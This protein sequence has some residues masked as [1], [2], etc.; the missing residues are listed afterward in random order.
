VAWDER[1]IVRPKKIISAV[2]DAV[3]ARAKEFGV[4]V[5]HAACWPPIM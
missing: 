2:K 3:E 5:R 4:G 1:A